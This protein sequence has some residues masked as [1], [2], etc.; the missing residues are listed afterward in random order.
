MGVNKD[1]GP[2][3]L[4]LAEECAELTQALMKLATYGPYPVQNGVQ[5]NN[6]RDVDAEMTDVLYQMQRVRRELSLA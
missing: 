4:R 5:Y 6:V 2:P 1:V 3:I